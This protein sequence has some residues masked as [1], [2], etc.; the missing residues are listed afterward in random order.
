MNVMLALTVTCGQRLVDHLGI[1]TLLD[2]G[3]GLRGISQPQQAA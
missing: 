1:G 3:C 2:C